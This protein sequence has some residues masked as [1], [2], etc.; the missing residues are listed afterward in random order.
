MPMINGYSDH[1]PPAFR[2]DALVLNS[3]PSHDSFR[4]LQKARVRYIGVHWDMFGP[5]AEEIRLRLTP[6]LPYLRELAADERMTL[7]EVVR[8]P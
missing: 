5:R 4:I 8:F 3:F 6:Y 1:T 7:Y 2:P